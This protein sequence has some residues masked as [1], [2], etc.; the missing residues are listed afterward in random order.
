MTTT[1]ELLAKEAGAWSTLEAAVGSLPPE[2]RHEGDVVPGWT[3]Q[4][5]LWHCIYWADYVAG[6]VEGAAAGNE[7]PA[8]EDW[9]AVNEQVASDGAAMTWDDIIAGGERVRARVRDA[10]SSL[11]PEQLTEDLAKEIV[12]E[13]ADHY[14]EHAAEIATFAAG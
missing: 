7:G 1:D 3:A 12:D 14:E 2:R 6:V 10:V 5:L 4:V 11:R 9:D 8:D 13:T